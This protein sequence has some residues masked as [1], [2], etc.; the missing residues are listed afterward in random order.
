MCK[1]GKLEAGLEPEF[2][3]ASVT[4]GNFSKFRA[5]PLES[6]QKQFIHSIVNIL[7]ERP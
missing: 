2:V 7:V 3:A 4:A 1:D 6:R 5:G